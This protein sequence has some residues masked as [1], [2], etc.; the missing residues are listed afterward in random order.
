MSIQGAFGLRRRGRFP[1]HRA[2]P[3]TLRFPVIVFALFLPSELPQPGRR[4]LALA[5][6]D[7]MR[8]HGAHML[9]EIFKI[10]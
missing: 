9:L 8:L 5:Q 1:A 2:I 7:D 3:S 10:G 4:R 6:L